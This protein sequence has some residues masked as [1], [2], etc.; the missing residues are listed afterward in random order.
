MNN[1][2]FKL[3]IALPLTDEKIHSRFF[4][5]WNLMS[6]P[7]YIYLRP[8]NPGPIDSVRNELVKQALES[9][10]THIIMMDTDQVYD[11]ETIEK[12]LGFVLS[13]EKYKV[14]GGKVHRRYPPFDHLCFRGIPGKYTLVNDKEIESGK[15][16]EVDATGCGCILY[17]IEV[18]KKIEQPW[19]EFGKTDE[20]KDIGE[21][22]NFC[23]KMKENG[24]KIYVD[25]SLDIKHMTTVEVDY[26]LYLLYRHINK[27]K[28]K[29]DKED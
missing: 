29:Y 18:F 15:V 17:D 12:L 26:N 9:E 4:D 27:L 14:C 2:N 10:C 23:Q 25:T 8:I 1:E 19:F 5:S 20:N 21:D 7:P 22:V 28:L 13:D 6:K 24:Y 16:I 11:P 3:G